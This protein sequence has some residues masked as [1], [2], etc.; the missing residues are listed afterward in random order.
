M[1]RWKPTRPKS[2][3]EKNEIAIAVVSCSKDFFPNEKKNNSIWS[4]ASME[5]KY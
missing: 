3:Q 5:K 2:L 4:F 1:Q